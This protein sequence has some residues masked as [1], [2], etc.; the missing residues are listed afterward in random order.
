MRK[1]VYVWLSY[2]ASSGLD[3][4]YWKHLCA[5]YDNESLGILERVLEAASWHYKI[6]ETADGL[7]T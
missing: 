5:V 1:D 4:G 3:S 7:G 6:T 2:P